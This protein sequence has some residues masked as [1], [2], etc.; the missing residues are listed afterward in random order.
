MS[1][2]LYPHG[3]GTTLVTID[4]LFRRNHVEK[5][6]PEYARRLRRWL[7]DQR[8]HIGIGG[9]WRSAG[10]QPNKPGFAPE[11]KSFHQYQTFASGIV[12]FA[13]VDLVAR[14][15]GN[16]HR[17][18]TWAEVP[19]QG[20]EWAKK[21]GV[22]ANVSTESWHLQP[23]EIDGFDSWKSAGSPDPA[24]NYPING[25]TGE[26]EMKIVNPP[27]RIHDSRTTA[28][29]GDSSEVVVQVPQTGVTAA[30]VNITIVEPAKQGFATAWTGMGTRPNVS[31]VNYGAGETICNT[32]WVPLSPSGAFRVFVRS[33]C[34]VVV[35][36]QAVA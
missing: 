28:K 14:N 36:L 24:S 19:A 12:A 25:D 8:G 13:A 22:H 17:S 23:I 21:Y 26:V 15:P 11:G 35:D 30:F 16:V 18:P 27:M 33:S 29:L 5:M 1:E 4:E 6:H 3:Y 31:N 9:S 7:I 10:S 20:S 32:S 2:T 34:H